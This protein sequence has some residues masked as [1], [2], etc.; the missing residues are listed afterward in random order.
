MNSATVIDL[1]LTRQPCVAAAATSHGARANI[2]NVRRRQGKSHGGGEENKIKW[3]T[4]GEHLQEHTPTN[5]RTHASP[6]TVSDRDGKLKR[7]PKGTEQTNT[8][9]ERPNDGRVGNVFHVRNV[10][11]AWFRSR[12]DDVRRQRTNV[13]RRVSVQTIGLSK[14]SL[15]YSGERNVVWRHTGDG[16]HVRSTF[17]PAAS[18]Y[19]LGVVRVERATRARYCRRTGAAMVRTK[20]RASSRDIRRRNDEW[21]ACCTWINNE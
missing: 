3:K 9:G 12:F 19:R 15:S 4:I 1:V 2:V 16:T 14:W 17:S 7:K 21:N 11:G 6:V 5:P 13:V 18:T 20:R 10:P 8:A